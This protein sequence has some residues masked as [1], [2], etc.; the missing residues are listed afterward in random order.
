VATDDHEKA[1]SSRVGAEVESGAADARAAPDFEA[2]ARLRLAADGHFAVGVVGCGNPVTDAHAVGAQSRTND[3]V[4]RSTDSRWGQVDRVPG[5]RRNRPIPVISPK[6]VHT[7]ARVGATDD[8]T[9]RCTGKHPGPADNLEGLRGVQNIGRHRS[10][11]VAR[12]RHRERE[13]PPGPN[14]E[15]SRIPLNLL[16]ATWTGRRRILDRSDVRLR[17]EAEP[18]DRDRTAKAW[19]ALRGRRV[20]RRTRHLARMPRDREVERERA[21]R[22]TRTQRQSRQRSSDPTPMPN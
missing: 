14:N 16:V 6:S 19:M 8:T 2:T 13:L 18:W 15:T 22:R 10:C 11:A 4:A 12:S 5:R 3:L 20:A 21:S 1:C 7:E 9:P 17:N